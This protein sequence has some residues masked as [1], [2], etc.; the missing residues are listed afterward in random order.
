M[1]YLPLAEANV[2]MFT[3]PFFTGLLALLLFGQRWA[4]FDWLLTASSLAGVVLVVRP[5]E[6]HDSGSG[7]E[8]H[9]WQRWVGVG[10]ALG[11]AVTLAAA[12]LIINAKIR[13]ESVNTVSFWMFLTV[14]CTV[15]PAFFFVDVDGYA[16]LPPSRVELWMLAGIGVLF[17][18]FQLTRSKAFLLAHGD[19]SVVNMLYLEIVCAFVWGVG[20]LQQQAPWESWAGATVIVL[21]SVAA[22]IAKARHDAASSTVT[23]DTPADP[24]A[25]RVATTAPGL[26][27]PLVR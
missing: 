23:A 21:G 5:W 22:G 1:N 9:N 17:W 16:A 2:L 14:V 11:F 12:N 10:C 27:E 8:T 26:Q 19:A 20:L 13:N 24:L 4:W 7:A 18:L 15:W 3:N 25:I 6:A